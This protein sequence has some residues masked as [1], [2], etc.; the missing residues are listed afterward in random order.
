MTVRERERRGEKVD[1]TKRMMI[2]EDTTAIKKITKTR[3]KTQR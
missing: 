3:R 1:E 2:G